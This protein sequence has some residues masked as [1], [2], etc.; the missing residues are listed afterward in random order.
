MTDALPKSTSLTCERTISS[1][2]I[3]SMIMTTHPI[4]AIDEDVLVLYVS[5]R[6]SLAIQ[7]VHGV[8]DLSKHVSRAILR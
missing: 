5:V 1:R 8:D 2:R 4:L 3:Y 6:N 7:V